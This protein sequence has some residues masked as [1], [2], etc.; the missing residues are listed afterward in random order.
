MTAATAAGALAIFILAA[1]LTAMTP[2]AAS[3]HRP[4]DVQGDNSDFYSAQLIPDHRAPWAISKE[5]DPATP[6]YYGLKPAPGSD[7]LHM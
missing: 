2:L 5:L 7:S 4:L 3:A 6:D 1:A